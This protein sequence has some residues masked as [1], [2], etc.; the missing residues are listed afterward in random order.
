[1]R[2]R[3]ANNV[4]E[5]LVLLGVLSWGHLDPSFSD[6]VIPSQGL[7]DYHMYTSLRYGL[8]HLVP[9]SP[10]S[11]VYP[12]PSSSLTPQPVLQCGAPA[13][14]LL[15][16]IFHPSCLISHMNPPFPPPPSERSPHG[17][18]PFK[19]PTAWCCDTSSWT[20]IWILKE[21][22]YS[23]TAISKAKSSR[24]ACVCIHDSW[25]HLKLHSSPKQKLATV[26][27]IKLYATG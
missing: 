26:E 27:Y 4:S 16:L 23:R 22:K 5:T 8:C 17:L 24:W 15:N 20:S 13:S 7:G 1:M 6:S 11:S 3:K 19:D 2:E 18:T 10:S 25:F 21:K 9:S 12:W 14:T